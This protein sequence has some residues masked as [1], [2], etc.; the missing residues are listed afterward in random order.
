MAG[1]GSEQTGPCDLRDWSCAFCVR[2]QKAKFL[3]TES[4]S[5]S[6]FLPFDHLL[7]YFCDFNSC[8]H[9]LREEKKGY[10]VS[11]LRPPLTS[12]PS[13][14]KRFRHLEPHASFPK[15]HLPIPRI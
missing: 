1:A 15:Q 5:Q 12:D 13:A 2:C 6:L 7:I 11:L 14:T 9:C 8:M 10:R 3:I 4:T